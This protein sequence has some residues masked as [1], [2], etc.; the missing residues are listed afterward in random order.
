MKRRVF[1]FDLGIASIGWAVVDF[2][3]EYY[4]METGEILEDKVKGSGEI[5]Q[6]KIVVCG[7]RS[8]PVAENPKD[9]SS[10]AAVRREKR[11][12]RR[13]CRRKA[14]RKEG[15]RGLFVAK[16]L[17]ASA[18]KFLE[19]ICKQQIGGDVWDLR[20]KAL[21]EKLSKEELLRVLYHLAKHRGFKSTR[22]AR[23]E[24]DKDCGKLLSAIREN[25]TLKEEGKSLAQIIVE[26]AGETGKKRNFT[27]I[28]KKGKNEKEVEEPD[29]RNSIPRS[30]IIAELEMIFAK[31]KEYG[32]FTQDLYD[33]FI[34]IAFRQRGIKSVG[35]MVGNCTFEKD[36]KRAPKE[37]PTSE[38]FVAWSKINNLTVYEGDKKRF[39]TPEERQMLFD[40]LKATKDVKYKT[41]GSKVFK[42]KK[43]QFACLNYSPKQKNNKNGEVVCVDPEDVLFYSM[44]GWHKLK[45]AF[46]TMPEIFNDT[47]K[48]DMAVTIIATEK[49]DARIQE[50]LQELGYS[51]EIIDKFLTLS[52]DK[53]I[54]LSVKALYKIN[55]YLEQGEKYDKACACAGYDFKENSEKL[56]EEK[57][58]LLP[59]LSEDKLPKVPVVNRA[60]AQFRKLYNALTRKYGTPDQVN[61][62]TGRELKKSFDERKEIEKRQQENRNYNQSAV[63]QIEEMGC[64]PTGTNITKLRL[65]HEQ[66]CKSM[67]SRAPLDLNRLFEIGYAEI[68]HILPYSRSFDNS[69]TNKVLVLANENQNKGNKT[70]FEYIGKQN[71][72]S[73]EW[74]D[75]VSYVTSIQSMPKG[76][77][78]KLLL[79]TFN[80]REQEFKDRNANDNS[81]IATFVKHYVEDCIDF[82]QSAH[83]N[84]KNKVQVRSG[85]VT[86]FLRHQWGLE[87]NRAESDNHH[88]QDAVVIACATQGM[89]QALSKIS[90]KEGMV[91]TEHVHRKYS[92]AQPWDNFRNE[93][94][95]A[96]ENVF[97]SRSPRKKATGE[98]HLET[99]YKKS[100]NPIKVELRGGEATKANMFRYDVYKVGEEYK[101]VP[102]YSIDLI[103]K[104]FKHYFQP[105]K[106]QLIEAKQEDFLFS[107]YKDNYVEIKTEE[108]CFAGYISQYNAQSGQIYL[109]SNDGSKIYKIRDKNQSLGYRLENEKKI[110]ISVIQKII[111]YDVS[112]LGEK[113]EIVKESRRFYQ[114][115][116]KPP[117]NKRI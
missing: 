51:Q 16:G 74:A 33:D 4:D 39:L 15:L 24:N 12:S 26:K 63:D 78:E 36:E 35:D 82:S 55:P 46:K 75:F 72:K 20:V 114:K 97:V 53:F 91:H 101:I 83:T 73:K 68:D 6:G 54:N 92:I 116:K 18:D 28:V 27:V 3:N 117:K 56:A 37:A 71:A 70:P 1:G 49:E 41:V 80:Q 69:Y 65:Y 14:R 8:F 76:K 89:V 90:R 109:E 84:I 2:D 86:A 47:Q 13:V 99:I 42:G 67:Y 106:E 79:E 60:I 32:I 25:M 66:Q 23:E 58:H 112:M 57:G 30:E 77:K 10:L 9:G 21:S 98:V 102:L 104:N 85:N 7:V 93:V 64:N 59:V 38:F 31:Q 100:N 45:S 48:L 108:E 110:N 43:I 19:D 62:E 61:I 105:A 111:K 44:K 50:K 17:V 113:N 88:A 11:L 107:L 5:S 95:S 52:F 115:E 103:R 87:K 22:K 81:Y 96:L 34:K 40:L 94:L 29:Y